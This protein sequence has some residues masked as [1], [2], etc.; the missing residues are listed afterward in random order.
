MKAFRHA[1]PADVKSAVAAVQQAHR[2]GQA[3]AVAGGGSDVLG[4]MKDRLI[5]PDVVVSLRGIKGLDQITAQ[6]GGLTIGGAATIDAISR[7]PVVRQRYRVLAEAAEAVATPQIRR[8]AGIT[9]TAS[10]V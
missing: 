8:G 7:H 6:G 10:T 1:S 4:M 2:A 3:V 9:G 5:A